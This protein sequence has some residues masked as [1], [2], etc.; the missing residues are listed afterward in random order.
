VKVEIQVTNLSRQTLN[1]LAL[2]HI[3]PAG[4]QIANPRLF[5][6][7][8]GSGYFDYQDVRDDR[9]LTYFSLQAGARKTFT[10]LL[11]ASYGGRFYQPGISVEAMYDAAYHANST[12]RWVEIRR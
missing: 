5:G 2:T 4:C 7:E 10:A 3:V 9:I 1:N 6:E 8:P 11:N 12:G